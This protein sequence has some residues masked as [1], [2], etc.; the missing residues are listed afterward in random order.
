MP[1]LD[2]NTYP[3]QLSTVSYFLVALYLVLT[4]RT[5]PKIFTS[6]SA[7]KLLMGK[8]SFSF[9]QAFLSRIKNVDREAAILTK[10]V[11]NFESYFFAISKSQ[12]KEVFMLGINSELDCLLA[13]LREERRY[14]ELNQLV[15]SRVF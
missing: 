3:H 5:M 1:Q 13:A 9:Y 4:L 10:A 12:G 7:R 15:L 11:G 14:I 2:V 6:I 8:T